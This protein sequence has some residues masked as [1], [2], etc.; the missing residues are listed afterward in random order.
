MSRRVFG[1]SDSLQVSI[2]KEDK[3]TRVWSLINSSMRRV[4]CVNKRDGFLYVHVKYEAFEV[5]MAA[6]ADIIGL[7]VN[8]MGCYKY[9]FDVQMGTSLK[10]ST[11]AGMCAPAARCMHAARTACKSIHL[12]YGGGVYRSVFKDALVVPVFFIFFLRFLFSKE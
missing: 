5:E 7:G 3:L 11:L 8:I 2:S 6:V 12:A 10:W 9:C 4:A 1:R